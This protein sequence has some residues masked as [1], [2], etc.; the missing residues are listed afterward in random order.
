MTGFGRFQGNKAG[1]GQGGYCICSNYPK[2]NYRKK[3]GRGSPCMDQT[4]PKC[5][6]S[7]TRE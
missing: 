5:G 3:H 2:C 4:C 1:A 6:A 7:L